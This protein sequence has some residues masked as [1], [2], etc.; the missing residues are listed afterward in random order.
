[1]ILPILT[2]R[3]RGEKLNTTINEDGLPD[4]SLIAANTDE[5]LRSVTMKIDKSKL[6]AEDRSKM[7]KLTQNFKLRVERNIKIGESEDTRFRH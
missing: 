5:I 7:K 1:M 4:T 3:Q 6:G 2:K